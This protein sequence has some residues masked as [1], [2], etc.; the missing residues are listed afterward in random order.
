MSEKYQSSATE[1]PRVQRVRIY[2]NRRP[3]ICVHSA[4][5]HVCVFAVPD[6]EQRDSA[7]MFRERD[8]VQ[9]YDGRGRGR[10]WTKAK[11]SES[12]G[13]ASREV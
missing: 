7:D 9:V 8:R 2:S 5:T 3:K 10:A 4:G 11:L 6:A 12:F 1:A 13:I